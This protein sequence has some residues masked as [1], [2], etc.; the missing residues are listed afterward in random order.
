[1][2]VAALIFIFTLILVIWQ[3]RGLGIG[4]SATLGAVLALIVG[5]ISVDD[6]PVV[7]DIVWNATFAFIAIIIIIM[8]VWRVSEDHVNTVVWDCLNDLF[9][10][11]AD[12]LVNKINTHG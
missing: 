4:V 11:T 10:F 9:T 7:W 12:Y 2:L 8:S 3:P 1:M 6:I 5:V